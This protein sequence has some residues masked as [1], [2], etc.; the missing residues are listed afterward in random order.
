MIL[1]I[2]VKT[3]QPKNEI[4]KKDEYY[5]VCIKERAEKGKANLA[6]IKL[7]KKELKKNVRIVSGFKSG[8]KLIEILS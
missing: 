5:F 6:V 1:K 3:N 4:I 8:E 2:K 7:F